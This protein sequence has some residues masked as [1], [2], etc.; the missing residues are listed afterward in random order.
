MN[1]VDAGQEAMLGA[2]NMSLLSVVEA[3]LGAVA[4]AAGERLAT[5]SNRHFA[6]RSSVKRNDTP[7]W[8]N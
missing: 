1:L 2:L 7:T 5:I 8:G 6:T 4:I 3:A